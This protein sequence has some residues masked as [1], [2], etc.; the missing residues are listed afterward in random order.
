[1]AKRGVGVID[2]ALQVGIGDVA[3][4]ETAD[5]IEGDIGVG[6]IGEGRDFGRRDLGPVLG[7][8]KSPI[9]RQAGEDRI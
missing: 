5:D 9:G 8:V 6:P 4:D 2:D 7:N 1:M 3:I